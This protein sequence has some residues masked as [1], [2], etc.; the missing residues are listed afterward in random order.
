MRRNR[1][2]LKESW[3]FMEHIIYLGYGANTAPDALRIM[4]A[5]FIE[6]LDIIFI[7]W[8][9]S[10]GSARISFGDFAT[11]TVPYVWSVI[12]LLIFI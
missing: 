4:P 5:L 7:D 1:I 8:I 12:V 6:L 9:A 2:R 10:D 3:S 11:V